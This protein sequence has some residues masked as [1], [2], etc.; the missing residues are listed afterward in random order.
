MQPE[1]L[2]NS[3]DCPQTL[4]LKSYCSNEM[5]HEKSCCEAMLPPA[6]IGYHYDD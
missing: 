2:M 3:S 6:K 5:N 4:M 1:M